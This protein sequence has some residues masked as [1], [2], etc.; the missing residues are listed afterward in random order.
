M[1]LGIDIGGTTIQLGLVADHAV[2]K[3][4][5][6]P[7]FRKEATLE[8]TVDYLAACTQ[9]IIV[10][11]VD[12]IGIGVPS[13]V[14]P[15]KGIV[16]DACNIPS[17]KTVYLKEEME[18]RFGVP[19]QVNN[20]A[21]C[22]ALGAASRVPKCEV[23][24]CVTLGTGTG[25]GIVIEGRLF[26]GT[27]C[28]AGELASI[29]YNGADYEQFCSKKFFTARGITDVRAFTEKADAGDAEALSLFEEFGRHLGAFLSVLMY[30][31]DP[32]CIVLGGGIAHTFHLFEQSLWK[33]LRE[34]YPYK[35]TL[36]DL[37][38]TAMPDG[39]L[40]VAGA[41]SL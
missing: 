19:V 4:V 6:V 26:N 37:C 38:I 10:P 14:D 22:Y 35:K 23:V 33:T 1:T 29:P 41:A 2:V 24:V 5:T 32:D 3:K 12:K 27:H 17:W 21:N 13:V 18:R 20:D 8:E 16:Y 11:E 28:G 36:E 40:A 25:V 9:E 30:A 39:D 15:V 31:Y 7:S 34:R